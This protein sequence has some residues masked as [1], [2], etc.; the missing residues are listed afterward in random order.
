MIAPASVLPSR[1]DR[2][3]QTVGAQYGSQSSYWDA[4]SEHKQ[5]HLA[6]EPA[7][8]TCAMPSSWRWSASPLHAGALSLS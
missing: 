3:L 7:C 2:G 4:R 1:A 5:A 8:E 6:R